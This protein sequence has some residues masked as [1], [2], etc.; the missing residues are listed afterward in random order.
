MEVAS[1][2]LPII[3]YTLL[4]ILVIFIIVFVYKLIKTLDKTNEILDDVNGKVKKLDGLFEVIDK[5]ADTINLITNRAVEV[6]IGAVSRLFKKK[7][8]DEEDE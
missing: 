8:K 2:L 1:E 4:S 7:R 6:V 3:L 5:S